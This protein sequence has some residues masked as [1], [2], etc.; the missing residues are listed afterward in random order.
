MGGLRAA[1]ARARNRKGLF[2]VPS[3]SVVC[4]D[5]RSVKAS[6]YVES[7]F[8]FQPSVGANLKTDQCPRFRMIEG[9]RRREGN[10]Q[11][12]TRRTIDDAPATSRTRDPRRDARCEAD[13]S[14]ALH[15]IAR[16]RTLRG[17]RRYRG[18]G[19]HPHFPCTDGYTGGTCRC[20]Q[21]VA[22]I[23]ARTMK[24]IAVHCSPLRRSFR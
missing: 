15:G 13:Q 23:D 18:P 10:D 24:P 19:P 16:S 1:V 5:V 11:R 3:R 2:S 14:G 21:T 4:P 22:P 9:G 20:A 6:R 12:D 8:N 7:N 17:V